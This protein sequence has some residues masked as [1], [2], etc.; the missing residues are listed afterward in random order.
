ML[1]AAG[2]QRLIAVT[3][4]ETGGSRGTAG[5]LHARV[6]FPLILQRIY[7]DKSAQEEIFAGSCVPRDNNRKTVSPKWTMTSA[8]AHDTR[9]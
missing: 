4:L 6:L 3:G 8:T 5:F 2:V 9:L 1:V 7:D